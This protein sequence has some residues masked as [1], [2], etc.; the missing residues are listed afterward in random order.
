MARPRTFPHL[1]C[2][3]F[4][5]WSDNPFLL[6]QAFSSELDADSRHENASKKARAPFRFIRNE[7]LDGME[8]VAVR[9]AAATQKMPAAKRASIPDTQMPKLMMARYCWI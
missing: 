6:T 3:V 4:V 7:A 8:S 1:E 9:L 2:G 5:F